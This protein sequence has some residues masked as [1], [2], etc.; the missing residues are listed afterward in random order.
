MQCTEKERLE[1][2]CLH[3]AENERAPATIEK[4]R[5]ETLEFL[6][7][8]KG[9]T[10]AKSLVLEYRAHL[11]GQNRP[12]TVNAKLSAIHAYLCFC[13]LGD[14]R[15]RLMKVQ[16]RAFLEERR[17]LSELE[18]KRLLQ[19]AQARDQER[20]YLVMLTLCA[21]GIRVSELQYI[22]REAAR[23]GRA[24]ITLKGKS[25]TALLPRDL[26]NRLL[27]YAAKH[28]IQ[29]GP[30]FRTRSGRPL[31][32]SN[33]CHDMKRLCSAA[34]VDPAKVFPHNLRHLFAR[35]FYA[36][37]KNL[38][39][40]ADILG[41]SSLETTRIYVAASVRAHE[42]TFEKMRLLL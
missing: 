9:R 18:Y 17:E 24:E 26:K 16:R 19:A 25:R 13:G 10:P 41:H 11:Q 21:T 28:G 34:R 15:V 14:C 38:A 42:R 4:Y 29:S 37:E 40:L 8:L 36:V 7:F 27:N 6:H 22:T 12:Q 23:R 20:L 3:L 31:D 5:K 30:I 39:H 33:I 1:A 2:F 32:R 35:R